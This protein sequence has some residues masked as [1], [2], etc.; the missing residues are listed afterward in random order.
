M[1]FCI[2]V[3]DDTRVSY[4]RVERAKC[5]NFIGWP[6]TRRG[7]STT[8]IADGILHADRN[9]YTWIDFVAKAWSIY[10]YNSQANIEDRLVPAGDI[11]LVVLYLSGTDYYVRAVVP[12]DRSI[13][14]NG[15]HEF[16]CNV[17][18]EAGDIIG[19]WIKA[20]SQF[21][22]Q[23]DDLDD[24]PVADVISFRYTADKPYA[25]QLLGSYFL[26]DYADYT[27][28]LSVRDDVRDLGTFVTDGFR[29]PSGNHGFVLNTDAWADGNVVD[30]ANALDGNNATYAYAANGNVGYIYCR[31]GSN[32]VPTEKI[33]LSTKQ[34]SSGSVVIATS[35][36]NQAASLAGGQAISDWKDLV[37]IPTDYNDASGNEEWLVH[38]GRKITWLRIKITGSGANQRVNQFDAFEIATAVSDGKFKTTPATANW[39]RFWVADDLVTVDITTAAS[40]PDTTVEIANATAAEKAYFIAGEKVILRHATNIIGESET[41]DDPAVVVDDLQL[42]SSVNENYSIG[43]FVDQQPAVFRLWAYDTNDNILGVG[44]WIGTWGNYDKR[45]S[46]YVDQ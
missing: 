8:Y 38:C 17:E 11:A 7:S 21:I 44:P 36:E 4:Y 39:K 40:V 12:S 29:D 28:S 10:N 15:V 26:T 2:D 35:E 9:L 23:G 16:P 22:W 3:P 37:D 34:Y 14:A 32:T 33:L 1:S 30:P 41:L 43:D 24:N 27:F 6:L 18:I 19:I 25:S 20:G 46:E 5:D 13:Q 42:V 45:I 31:L